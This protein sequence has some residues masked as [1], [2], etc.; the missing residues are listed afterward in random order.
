MFTREV[1]GVNPRFD[2]R[3]SPAPLCAQSTS[4]ENADFNSFSLL[5][6]T[7]SGPISPQ[8]E[9]RPWELLWTHP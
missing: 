4:Q 1:S 3:V 6:L 8:R 9:A 7:I 5:K 2:A